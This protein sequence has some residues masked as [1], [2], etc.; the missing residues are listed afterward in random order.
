MLAWVQLRPLNAPVKAL[1]VVQPLLIA[2]SRSE[3]LPAPL[4]VVLGEV[5][6]ANDRSDDAAK[7]LELA[8][9]L[10]STSAR[11]YLELAVIARG[12]NEPDLAVTYL[13]RARAATCTP[14]DEA[15]LRQTLTSIK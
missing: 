7:C 11:T 10:G 8:L 13:R 3:A 9:N 2:R 4:L 5:L 14:L 6:R 12:R 1:A 15:E